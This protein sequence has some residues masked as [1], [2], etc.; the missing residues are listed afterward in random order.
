MTTQIYLDRDLIL[1]FLD[2][3][4][5]SLSVINTI[6]N[7][8]DEISHVNLTPFMYH[9]HQ[10][11]L[12]IRMFNIHLPSLSS[13]GFATFHDPMNNW[14]VAK[15]KAEQIIIFLYQKLNE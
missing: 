5:T 12:G 9:L 2:S 10:C 11:D 15:F 4:S 13:L 1:E 8:T 6:L 3:Y 7:Q 14:K